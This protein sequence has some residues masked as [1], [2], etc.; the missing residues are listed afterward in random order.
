MAQYHPSHQ[1]FE[2]PLLNRPP[3]GEELK[4]AYNLAQEYGLKRLD[5]LSYRRIAKVP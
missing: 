1:A 2:V 5:G 4:E 3:T